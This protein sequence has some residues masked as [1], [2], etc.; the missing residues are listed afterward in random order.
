MKN[1]NLTS[2]DAMT[3]LNGRVTSPIAVRHKG[4]N[5]VLWTVERARSEGLTIEDAIVEFCNRNNI[6]IE[7]EANP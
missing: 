4:E 1:E 3:W 6:N 7:K 5:H 2:Q